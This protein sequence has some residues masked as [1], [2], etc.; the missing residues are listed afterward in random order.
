MKRIEWHEDRKMDFTDTGLER[1]LITA[2]REKDGTW[3]FYEKS[4]WDVCWYDLP[5]TPELINRAEAQSR[6]REY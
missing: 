5:S 6:K 3:R 2:E 1:F 4:I